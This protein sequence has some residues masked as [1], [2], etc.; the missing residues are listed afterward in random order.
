[1]RRFFAVGTSVGERRGIVRAYGV[2]WVVDRERGGVRWSGLRVVARGP[3]G[4]V[5]YAVVR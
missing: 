4:Q 5:L 2:R 1:M 3:G